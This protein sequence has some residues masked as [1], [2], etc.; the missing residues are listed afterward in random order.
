MAV[1]SSAVMWLV[2]SVTFSC[3]LPAAVAYLLRPVARYVTRSSW[4]HLPNPSTFRPVRLAA[5]QLSTT[6]PV[7]AS[8]CLSPN[9]MSL[10]VWQ[11][12]QCPRPLTRYSPRRHC[13]D[14]PA[15][16]TGCALGRYSQF[17]KIRPMR[18][19]K[20]KISL[21]GVGGLGTGFSV[22]R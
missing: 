21:L 7:N 12:A 16:A 1:R 5:Y 19:L 6:P 20:G 11:P 14:W 4:L 10:G 13:S 18:M 17:Q 3:M 22:F 9:R 8:A 2:D 15:S